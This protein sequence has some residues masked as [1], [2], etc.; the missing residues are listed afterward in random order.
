MGISDHSGKQYRF[1]EIGWSLKTKKTQHMLHLLN[2]SREN[3]MYTQGL[4][5]SFKFLNC[6]GL[7]G[8]LL[9]MPMNAS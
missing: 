5:G 1:Q 4:Q 7:T 2:F 9:Q 3:R 6:A 8:L